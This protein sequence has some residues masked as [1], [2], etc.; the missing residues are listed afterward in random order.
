MKK[1]KDSLNIM[2][3]IKQSKSIKRHLT[4]CKENFGTVPLYNGAFIRIKLYA[5]TWA[6]EL[7]FNLNLARNLAN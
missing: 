5:L 4:R 1:K 6:E 2:I 7:N 3:T